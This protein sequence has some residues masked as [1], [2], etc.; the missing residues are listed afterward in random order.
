[1]KKLVYIKTNYA[2]I[3]DVVRPCESDDDSDS[4]SPFP[5]DSDRIL[6][7]ECRIFPSNKASNCFH[8]F[9]MVLLWFYYGFSMVLYGVLKNRQLSKHRIQVFA[10]L[11]S[12]VGDAL[13]REHLSRT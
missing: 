12:T 3:A 2:A 8:G 1:V 10:P 7:V 13:S 6:H 9:I 5:V 11:H 4:D